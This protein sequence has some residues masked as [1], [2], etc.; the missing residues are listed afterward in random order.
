MRRIADEL[1]RRHRRQPVAH[2]DLGAHTGDHEGRGDDLRLAFLVAAFFSGA[3]VLRGAQVSG[4]VAE[5][6]AVVRVL[7][8]LGFAEQAEVARAGQVAA[9]IGAVAAR[10][11]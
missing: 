2:A 8:R 1:A 6:L 11:Q 3:R 4:L 9:H 10:H 7:Q 5:D